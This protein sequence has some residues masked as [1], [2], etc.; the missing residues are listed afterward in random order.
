MPF[1]IQEKWVA[2]ISNKTSWTKWAIPYMR[3]MGCRDKEWLRN[4]TSWNAKE[5]DYVVEQN[6]PFLVY[7]TECSR[8]MSDWWQILFQNWMPL[9]IMLCQ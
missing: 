1:L 2:K 7:G 8:S 5:W 3:K 9:Q 6:Q 4:D